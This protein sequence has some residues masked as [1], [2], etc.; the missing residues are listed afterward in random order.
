ML[1]AVPAPFLPQTASIRRAQEQRSRGEATAPAKPQQNN[2]EQQRRRRELPRALRPS[3]LKG[4]PRGA[5]A[6]AGASVA[7]TEPGRARAAGSPPGV[8][9]R[10]LQGRGRRERESRRGATSGAGRGSRVLSTA[11]SS[12]RPLRRRCGRFGTSCGRGGAFYDLGSGAGRPVVA[13]AVLFPF[14]ACRGVELLAGLSR[15][16]RGQRLWRRR[17]GRSATRPAVVREGDITD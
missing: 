1:A 10:G 11:R 5:P 8:L 17:S 12:T 2:V 6:T 3:S 13:A 15:L 14:R 16:A 9:R 7:G 4:G